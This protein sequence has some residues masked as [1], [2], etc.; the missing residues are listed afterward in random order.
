M[1]HTAFEMVKFVDKLPMKI[2]C[3]ACYD[4]IL[5][6]ASDTGRIL[7]Y[8][9]HV[10]SHKLESSFER[11]LS[12]TKKPVQQMEVCKEFNVLVVMFDAQI[13]VFNLAKYELEYSIPKTKNCSLFALS[14]SKDKKLL[15]M[16]VACKRRLQFY[17]LSKSST[18][19]AGKFM[20]L[21]SDLE[22]ADTPRTLEFTNE[23]LIVFSLRKEFF[24]YRVP[25]T[26]QSV[27]T[28]SSSYKQPESKFSN[29]TRL[30]EPLCEK[31]HN[32]CFIIGM[33]E[34]KTVLYDADG[35]PNLEYPINWIHSPSQVTCVGLY[36]IGILPNLNCVEVVTFK[37]T[38]SSVQLIE[39]RTFFDFV[40]TIF[41]TQ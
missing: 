24:Y 22:L 28:S 35:K 10:N 6:V 21:I 5:L 31:L 18:A 15:R 8:E 23:N 16:C 38:P 9:V 14:M 33:D 32:D 12:V 37:P 13:H 27:N 1:T 36:L 41:F 7:V 30:I 2:E 11:S 17:Y 29:G 19:A 34:N 40:I 20:E 26:S 3:I 4:N 25:T 39:I